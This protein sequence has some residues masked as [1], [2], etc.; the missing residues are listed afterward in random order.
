MFK[1]TPEGTT[2][3]C[4]SCEIQARFGK[5]ALLHTCGLEKR[6]YKCHGCYKYDCVCTTVPEREEKSCN[7]CTVRGKRACDPECDCECH[8]PPSEKQEAEGWEKEFDRIS[9]PLGAA[10]Q[11]KEEIK[12]F[13]SQTRK[14][15]ALKTVEEAEKEYKSIKSW[16]FT[17]PY[18][19]EIG[20]DGKVIPRK[21]TD[22]EY[23]KKSDVLNSLEKI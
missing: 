1:D 21:R 23:L 20:D 3:Y 17:A 16:V 11:L 5:T 12:S 7:G 14:E 19:L 9:Y 18:G 6:P 10:K 22:D 4:K 15:V 8:N 2:Q 13:I